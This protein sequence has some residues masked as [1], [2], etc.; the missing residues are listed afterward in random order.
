[1]DVTTVMSSSARAIGVTFTMAAVGIIL[2]RTGKLQVANKK[3]LATI[4]MNVTIPALLFTNL[5]D[6]TQDWSTEACPDTMKF[7]KQGW[8]LLLLPLFN[9]LVGSMLGKLICCV[10][11]PADNYRNAVV[12]A[13]AFGNSTGLPVTL[14][15]VIR[16]AFSTTSELGAV[17]P[18]NFLSV[19]LITYPVIQW[20]LGGYLM[21][22]IGGTPTPDNRAQTAEEE[23]TASCTPGLTKDCE[24]AQLEEGKLTEGKLQEGKLTDTLVSEPEPEGTLAGLKQVFSAFMQPAVIASLLGIAV[25]TTS[26]TSLDVRALLV[27]TR[28]RDDDRPLEFL[29]DGLYKVGQAAVPINM[30]ILGIGLGTFN[31]QK[32]QRAPWVINLLVV[33]CKMVVMP[34]VGV[35]S[36]LLL[37][38]LIYVD[39]AMDASFYLVVML[40]SA[41]PTANN[42]V[43]MCELGGQDKEAMASCIFT[44]YLF[45]L[46]L[47]GA[48]ICVMVQIAST[49]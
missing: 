35:A 37:R 15:Q 32:L 21:G 26:G 1:M 14:I 16:A 47:L 19:Y 43:S 4:S 7:V 39:E 17:N 41:T 34:A 20:A 48:S 3:T 36:T 40:V 2:V 18:N 12:A 25:A 42:I 45:A 31:W 29:Y 24:G 23:D 8:P 27:D 13:V 11:K 6:C 28:D 44:Q 9:V 49:Y 30:L 22:S 38:K 10:T 5:L 33:F 46:L